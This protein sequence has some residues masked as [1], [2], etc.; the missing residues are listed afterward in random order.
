MFQLND[1]TLEL[2]NLSH[3][4]IYIDKRIEL[5]ARLKQ[6]AEEL[7]GEVHPQKASPCFNLSQHCRMRRI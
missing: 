3:N 4:S 7:L 2:I 5:H 1:D 6:W